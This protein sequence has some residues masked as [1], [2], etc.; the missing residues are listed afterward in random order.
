MRIARAWSSPKTV[1]IEIRGVHARRR[2]NRADVRSKLTFRPLLQ[3]FA[4]LLLGAPFDRPCAK[5]QADRHSI[6]SVL[7]ALRSSH[8]PT[9]WNMAPGATSQTLRPSFS[10]FL[11][12]ASF[13]SERVRPPV[14]RNGT[15]TSTLNTIVQTQTPGPLRHR[16]RGSA[17][18]SGLA[19]LIGLPQLLPQ[20]DRIITVGSAVERLDLA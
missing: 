4:H 11:W 1:C 15:A 2:S 18:G 9:P 5:G 6:C 12:I 3:Q 14:H 16:D 17:A 19:L 10:H 7:G 13:T 20:D 8:H